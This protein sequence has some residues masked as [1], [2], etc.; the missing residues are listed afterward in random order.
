MPAVELLPVLGLGTLGLL[1]CLAVVTLIAR[2]RADRRPGR[3]RAT[4]ST[5]GAV[6]PPGTASGAP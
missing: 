2:G 3:H 4:R 1:L 6:P 5:E